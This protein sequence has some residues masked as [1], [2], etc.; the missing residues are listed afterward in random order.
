LL[1]GCSLLSTAQPVYTPGAR[2]IVRDAEWLVRRVDQTTS[3]GHALTVTGLSEL[4]RDREAIFLTE[5]DGHPP[6]LRPED[7]AFVAD[8]STQFRHALL[9]L[10]SRLRQLPPTFDTL[11]SRIHL[12]HRAAMDVLDY[13]LEPALKALDQPR[14]RLLIA[15]AVGLGKTLEAGILLSELIARGRG[16]R[17]LV[18]TLKSML[19]QF[20]KEMWNRFTIP[21]VRLDSVGLERVRAWIPTNHNPFHYYD[22]TIISIDTLKQDREYRTYLEQAHWDVIVIDEAHHVAARGSTSMRNRLAKLLSGRS[23]TLIMLSATPHD[24]SARS[25]AS[26]MNMLNPTAIANP[27]D[28]TKDDIK[29]LYIRRFKKDV[30]DQLTGSSLPRRME[31]YEAEASPAEELAYDALTNLSLGDWASRRT[32]GAMLFKTTLE[33][34]LF[35]SPAACL[36]TVRQRIKKLE[37]QT[38]N[39]DERDL[40]QL[41]EFEGHLEAIG[42]GQFSKYQRLLTLLQDV[43]W[44]G[45]EPRERLVIFTERIETMTWL[46]EHLPRDLGLADRHVAV[47]HGGLS[48]VEQQEIVEGFGTLDSPLRLLIASDVASEGL[49]LHYFCHHLVHFDIP[50]SL[51]IFQQRNGRI[52]R[53]GQTA[54]PFIFYLQTASRNGKIRGD[55][56]ILELLAQKDHQ[57]VRN[58]GDP[59]ALLNLYDVDKEEGF[60]ASAMERGLAV[61]AV[62]QEIDEAGFDFLALLAGEE[63]VTESSMGNRLHPDASLFP[64]DYTYAKTALDELVALEAAKG[65]RLDLSVEADDGTRTLRFPMPPELRE[66][67][68]QCPREADPGAEPLRLTDNRERMKQAMLEARS[69]DGSWPKL[70]YLWPLHPFMGWLNDKIASRFGRNEAPIIHLSTGLKPGE[71]LYLLAGVIPNRKGHPLIQSWFGVSVQNGREPLVMTFEEVLS[72]TRLGQEKIANT[73]QPIDSEALRSRLP[74]VVAAARARLSAERS[75]FVEEMAGKLQELLADLA[76]LQA[77]RTELLDKE[78]AQKVLSDERRAEERSARMREISREFDTWRSWIVDTLNTEDQPHLQVMA[79]LCRSVQA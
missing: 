12:G 60:T 25:F 15:D 43:H 66:R 53:Y 48:D 2:I 64:D 69:G 31:V 68:R 45:H 46:R 37:T 35:S 39:R 51:M 13:Q 57:A 28:Y 49:N 22:K 77:K 19:T 65:N 72:R 62:A 33:K 9:Y 3:G 76:Q 70:Q 16:K 74:A 63:P 73:L 71:T 26:L 32:G 79:A 40:L 24:G 11:E 4:V 17:I 56:R 41:R 29:G 20:Q 42:P 61:E 14:A 18:L 38:A 7:T 27:D 23:D 30:Q 36:Q 67:F 54:T 34:A 75:K 10:E 52:D 59:S 47:M 6:L 21:L 78:L 55:Q 44:R 8:P 58:I 1:K 50:W 5:L